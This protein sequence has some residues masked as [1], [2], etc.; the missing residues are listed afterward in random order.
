MT[1]HRREAI[2]FLAVQAT[3][4]EGAVWDRGRGVL[5]F[6]DIAASTIYRLTP[7]RGELASWPA[8][9]NVGW[10]AP[11]DDGDLVAGLAN[12]LYR[13]APD[14][15]SFALLQPV[16]AE[17]SDTRLNDGTRDANGIYWFGTL[18]GSA[19]AEGGR[20]YRYDGKSVRDAGLP[21]VQIT[22]G[23]A[24]SPDGRTLYAVD[25]LGRTI[26]AYAIEPGGQVGEGRLFVTIDPADGY[27][28]GV[29]CDAEGGVWLGLWNGWSARRYDASG[30]LTD[31]VRFPVANV[32]KVALGGPDGRTAYATTARE[33]QA[34]DTSGH[35][36]LGGDLFTF[37]VRV[38]GF[39]A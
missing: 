35:Q 33:G 9:Q 39:S 4:G 17:R 14:Q 36:P 13:F 21:P 11:D 7:E 8:P 27:P 23:P 22:N 1:V 24:V 16:E 34:G 10:V 32:T 28:D 5:W 19:D 25:T 12:G 26:H 30:A 38:P 37:P 2:H 3:L 18:C 31:E 20:F 15:G 29:T 6:V